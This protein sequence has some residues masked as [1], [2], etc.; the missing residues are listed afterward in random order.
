M[1]SA[2]GHGKSQNPKGTGVV[3]DSLPHPGRVVCPQLSPVIQSTED[4]DEELKGRKGLEH[5]Q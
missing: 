5:D 1:G 2:W 3:G 4:E